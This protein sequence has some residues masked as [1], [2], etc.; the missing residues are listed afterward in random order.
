MILI[1]VLLLMMGEVMMVVE[2]DEDIYK[3]NGDKSD[4]KMRMMTVV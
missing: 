3:E 2:S 4:M 1:F